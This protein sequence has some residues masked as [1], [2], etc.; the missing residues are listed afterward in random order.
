MTGLV[1]LARKLSLEYVCNDNVFGEAIS[2]V[3][4]V[5]AISVVGKGSF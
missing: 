2:G 5:I 3:R 1:V 4:D